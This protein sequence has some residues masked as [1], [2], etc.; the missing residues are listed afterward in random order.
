M[1]ELPVNGGDVGSKLMRP[2]EPEKSG[3]IEE[4][5]LTDANYIRTLAEERRVNTV[6]RNDSKSSAK[7]FIHCI[8]GR[9]DVG[10]E[11]GVELLHSDVLIM[12][13]RKLL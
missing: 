10:V 7:E 9:G 1:K 6:L 5:L 8:T 12:R 4:T 13:F 2:A 3:P 11:D